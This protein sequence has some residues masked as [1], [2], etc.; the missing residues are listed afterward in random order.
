MRACPS[1]PWFGGG[2]TAACA[3]GRCEELGGMGRFVSR[4]D[5][6][7][8]KPNMA[9]DRTPEQAANTNPDVVAETARLCLDAGA[10]TVIVT[11]VSINEPRRCFRA[12]RHRRGCA[13]RRAPR[14]CCP[15]RGSFK[16]VDLRGDLLRVLAGLG[17]L[18]AGRQ[19]DQH[20]RRQAPQPHR[21]HLGTQELVR[22]P[23]RAA[24]AAAPA[25]P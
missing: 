24:P 18:P 16:R 25:H 2:S 14:L 9:W 17:T 3:P 19:D 23:G 15:R 22:D 4:G 21:R 6:V 11:D 12:Q 5:V 8:I 1:W 13:P 7:V 20:A 10:K